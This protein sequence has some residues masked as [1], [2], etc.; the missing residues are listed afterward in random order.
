[1]QNLK[2]LTKQLRI[3]SLQFNAFDPRFN[4]WDLYAEL[5]TTFDDLV[6]QLEEL[7]GND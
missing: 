6:T 4:S 7:T 2:D 3:L 1:M 5:N